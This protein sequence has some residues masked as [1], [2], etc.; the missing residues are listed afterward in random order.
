MVSEGKVPPPDDGPS[1]VGGGGPRVIPNDQP[2][3]E[4]L[5]D[6]GKYLADAVEYARQYLSTQADRLRVAARNAILMLIVGMVAAMI[7]ATILISAT[8]LLCMGIADGLSVLLGG[9]QWA[10]DLITAGLVLGSIAIFARFF[11]GGIMRTSREKTRM[12]YEK[13]RVRD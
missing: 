5:V 7:A 1:A 12:E 13:R 6:A 2:A 4:S 10:G 11:I 3:T 8:V 9:R